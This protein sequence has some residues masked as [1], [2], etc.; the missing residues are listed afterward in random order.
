EYTARDDALRAGGDDL[1][2]VFAVRDTEADGSRDVGLRKSCERVVSLIA[3]VR[4]RTGRP[5]ASLDVDEPRNTLQHPL[6]AFAARRRRDDEDQIESV[7]VT[8]G[9]QR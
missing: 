2:G 5:E 8:G 3:H 7:C 9:F 4:A 6:Q 1:A